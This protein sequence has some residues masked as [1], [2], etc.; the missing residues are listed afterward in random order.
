MKTKSKDC[1]FQ[2]LFALKIYFPVPCVANVI[3]ALVAVFCNVLVLNSKLPFSIATFCIPVGP[4]YLAPEHKESLLGV[5]SKVTVRSAEAT[6]AGLVI[7]CQIE[8]LG[9]NPELEVYWGAQDGLTFADRWEHSQRIPNVKEGK[10]EF[11]L[12]SVA[13]FGNAKLR[14]FL[15]N[16]DGQFW[17]EISARVTK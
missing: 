8:S 17:S 16:D 14:L 1:F 4:V 3:S 6:S 9:S 7:K 15:K 11:A 2:K 12:K 5:P 13:P 10:N